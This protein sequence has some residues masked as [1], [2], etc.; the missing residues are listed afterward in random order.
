MS[1]DETYTT[2][3]EM[4]EDIYGAKLRAENMLTSPFQEPY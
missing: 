2:F 4:S 1:E 3:F